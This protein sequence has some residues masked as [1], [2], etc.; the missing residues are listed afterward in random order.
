M[1]P[2][3]LYLGL[4]TKAE[5]LDKEQS[6]AFHSSFFWIG[7]MIKWY[8]TIVIEFDLEERQRTKAII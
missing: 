8:C 3:L 6:S 2:C 1:D 4:G 5:G 7:R